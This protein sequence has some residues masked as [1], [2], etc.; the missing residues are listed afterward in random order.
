MRP[1][2]RRRSHVLAER[3]AAPAAFMWPD[4]LPRIPQESALPGL[5]LLLSISLLARK[6]KE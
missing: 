2:I 1:D 6:T 3:V 4:G 5:K